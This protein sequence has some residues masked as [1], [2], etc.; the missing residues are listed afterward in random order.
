[1]SSVDSVLIFVLFGNTAMSSVDSVLIL[2][3]F[4]NTTMSSVD[5][6]MRMEKKT[7]HLMLFLISKTFK[8]IVIFTMLFFL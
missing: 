2:V 1:M 4:G 8:L 5:S 6:K 7:L 3:L